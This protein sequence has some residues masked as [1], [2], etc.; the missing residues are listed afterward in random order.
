MMFKLKMVQ[1]E[2]SKKRKIKIKI[3]SFQNL[4]ITFS[5][6]NIKSGCLCEVKKIKS[7]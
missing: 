1:R 6:A 4:Y 2:T 7:E 3:I 5:P